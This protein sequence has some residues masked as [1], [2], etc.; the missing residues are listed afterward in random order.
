MSAHKAK[1]P[2][3]V[4]TR[5]GI[6]TV[7]HVLAALCVS[8]GAGKVSGW[9]GNH[10]DLIAAVILAA[11]PLVA[12]FLARRH[13]TPLSSPRNAAGEK[14]APVSSLTAT[15]Q[16]AEAAS[17]ADQALAEADA[18]HPTNPTSGTLPAAA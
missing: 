13:V 16:V 6:V 2:Q 9:L 5:A 4:L 15:A 3:P 11:A 14:L 17:A 7:I 1:Q 10:A 8:L 18:I 12:G